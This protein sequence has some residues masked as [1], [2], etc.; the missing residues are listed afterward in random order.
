MIEWISRNPETVAAIV[1]ALLTFA[2]GIVN[3]HELN[4]YRGALQWLT[5]LHESRQ[6]TGVRSSDVAR[7]IGLDLAANRL[8]LE[9]ASLICDSAQDSDDK[10]ENVPKIKRFWRRWLW[11]VVRSKIQSEII[12]RVSDNG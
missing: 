9:S 1:G 11:P 6:A 2:W 5:D 10:K 4:R 8:N 3:R 12:E 7:N